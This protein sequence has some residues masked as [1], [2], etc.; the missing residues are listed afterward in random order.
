MQDSWSV[1]PVGILC[2]MNRYGA[3]IDMGRSVDFRPPDLRVPHDYPSLSAVG[4]EVSFLAVGAWPLG[5][6]PTAKESTG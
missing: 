6:A 3:F 1:G 4:V 2:D 5:H